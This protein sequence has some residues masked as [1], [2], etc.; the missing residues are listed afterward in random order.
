MPAFLKTP[1]DERL[2]QKAKDRAEEQ[3]HKEDWPYI[4]G[5]WKKMKGKDASVQKVADR[6]L[7]KQKPL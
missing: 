5:I 6:W 1:E 3:G 4:T 7:K 2:W